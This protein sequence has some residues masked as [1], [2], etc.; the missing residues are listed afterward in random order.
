MSTSIVHILTVAGRG[1]EEVETACEE[2]LS[3]RVERQSGCYG[4]DDWSDQD[5]KDIEE[6]CTKLIGAAH[7]LPVVYYAQYLDGW[8]VANSSCRLLECPD[9][10]RRLI[11]GSGFGL[12]FYPSR[13]CHDLL[14]Q[15]T[16]LRRRKLYRTQAED[17]WFLD[18]A[19]EA[20]EAAIWLQ[21][22]FLVVYISQSVGASRYDEEIKAAIDTP[23]GLAIRCA[24]QRRAAEDSGSPT[25]GA[26]ACWADL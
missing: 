21:R 26:G 20:S 15:L 2:L 4:S 23:I 13:Y 16:R 9:G 10:K 18:Q 14:A 5:H 6:L 3:R 17:R 12:A 7:K 22:T 11:F 24:D 8:S 19:R 1:A 25:R